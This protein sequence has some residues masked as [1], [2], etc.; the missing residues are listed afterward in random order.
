MLHLYGQRAQVK[1]N[2]LTMTNTT[3]TMMTITN[4]TTVA[5]TFLSVH[6]AESQ[7]E[8]WYLSGFST[9]LGK[10]F[11]HVLNEERVIVLSLS[12]LV[13]WRIIVRASTLSSQ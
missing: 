4:M 10:F 13:S 7:H 1:T 8:D 2:V 12:R 9:L 3:T 5:D 11:G 6:R